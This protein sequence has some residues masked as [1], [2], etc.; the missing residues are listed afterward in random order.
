MIDDVYCQA[1]SVERL[2]A[3]DAGE[4]GWV[5]ITLHLKTGW[6]YTYPSEKQIVKWDDYSQLNGMY[7]HIYVY[8]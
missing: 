4:G 1:T 3:A 6:W 7:Y 2:G 8:I 5:V